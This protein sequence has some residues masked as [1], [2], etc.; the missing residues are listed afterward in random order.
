MRRSG[1]MPRVASQC[2][3]SSA[4]TTSLPSL[5]PCSCAATSSSKA[6]ATPR[7]ESSSGGRRGARRGG[8][9][10]AAAWRQLRRRA[11]GRVRRAEALA[12]RLEL[13]HAAIDVVAAQRFVG[14]FAGEHDGDLFA[15]ALGQEVER[16][17]GGIGDR[18]VE[19]PDDLGQR[20]GGL[21]HGDAHLAMLGAERAGGEARVGELVFRLRV[22]FGVADREGLERAAGVFGAQHRGGDH[23]RVEAAREE[24]ADA[25]PRT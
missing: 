18:L 12:Q 2:G 3:A 24:G 8:S 15:R 4:E 21:A 7:Y 5:R 19:V 16:H 25:A 6:R 9:A 10:R 20:V 13:G 23:R 11:R 1:V 17:A 14:A 22:V